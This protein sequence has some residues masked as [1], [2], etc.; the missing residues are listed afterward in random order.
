MGFFRCFPWFSPFLHGL[1]ECA[2]DD[3]PLLFRVSLW[4]WTAYPDTR[5]VRLG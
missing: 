2:G 5:M 1:V 4:K 3:L